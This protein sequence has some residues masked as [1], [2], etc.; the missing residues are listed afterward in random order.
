MDRNIFILKEYYM[1]GEFVSYRSKSYSFRFSFALSMYCEFTLRW[2]HDPLRTVDAITPSYRLLEHIVFP[3]LERIRGRSRDWQGPRSSLNKLHRTAS[4]LPAITREVLT[5][6]HN[7]LLTVEIYGETHY[8]L[9]GIL[10]ADALGAGVTSRK[11]I[12]ILF[13]KLFMRLKIVNK[14]FITMS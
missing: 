8:Y 7:E 12:V 10:Q 13:R 5:R 3:L 11:C 4:K 6:G 14:F 9:G 2:I 1:I